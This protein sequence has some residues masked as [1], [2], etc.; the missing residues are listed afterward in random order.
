MNYNELAT[1]AF[2]NGM[3]ENLTPKYYEFK[4]TGQGIVG[5]YKGKTPIDSNKSDKVYYQ[6]LFDTDEGLIKF[7]L[8]VVTDSEAGKV[9]IENEIYA[10]QY[11]GQEKIGNSKSVNKFQV[12][13]ILYNEDKKGQTD[14]D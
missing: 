6:Y 11:L 14:V 13:H 1:K 8:G 4:E 10:I 7:H 3:T 12:D 2:K 9:M 5:R